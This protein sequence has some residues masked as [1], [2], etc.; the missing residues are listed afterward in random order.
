MDRKNHLGI[1]VI[2]GIIIFDLLV[3]KY[4]DENCADIILPI[5][6]PSGKIKF[7]SLYTISNLKPIK[8]NA[9][10]IRPRK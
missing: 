7:D 6:Y 4:Q 3:Y 8:Q 9:D 2:V 5:C 10:S 1:A